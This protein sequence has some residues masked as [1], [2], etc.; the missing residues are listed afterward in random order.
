MV[1][2]AVLV[3]FLCLVAGLCGIVAGVVEEWG[4]QVEVG[5]VPLSSLPSRVV[6]RSAVCV[7]LCLLVGLLFRGGG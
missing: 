1:G 7:S 5:Y 2:A 6:L 4:V 3:P